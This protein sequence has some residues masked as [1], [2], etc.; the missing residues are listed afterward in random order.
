MNSRKIL[1]DVECISMGLPPLSMGRVSAFNR[2]K[3]MPGEQRTKGSTDPNG[4]Y[5]DPASYFC[6]SNIIRG[7]HISARERLLSSPQPNVIL[8]SRSSGQ[9]HLCRFEY[10]SFCLFFAAS[11]KY[12]PLVVKNNNNERMPRLGNVTTMTSHQQR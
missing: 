8:A 5:G 10:C 1:F 2:I 12:A 6:P 3:K 7:F 9:D 4:Q 11:S